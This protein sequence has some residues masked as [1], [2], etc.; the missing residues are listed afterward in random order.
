MPHHL[1][2]SARADVGDGLDR[3]LG[4]KTFNCFVDL[5][6]GALKVRWQA[7]SRPASKSG[8]GEARVDLATGKVTTSVGKRLPVERPKHSEEIMKVIRKQNWN[9]ADPIVAAGGR[10][11]GRTG[12]AKGDAWILT[13]NVADLKT[14]ELLWMRVIQEV[15][16]ASE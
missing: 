9:Q 15:R 11:F 5:D 14:G 2:Q 1:T 16:T 3:F 6:G 7:F 13:L 12:G 10:V 8:F 4:A